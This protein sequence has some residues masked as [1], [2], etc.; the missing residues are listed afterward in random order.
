MATQSDERGSKHWDSIAQRW[1]LYS[2][3][4]RPG[5]EDVETFL[6]VIRSHAPEPGDAPRQGLILGVTPE[7]ATM[8]WPGRTMVTGADR[9]QEM[10]EQVWPGDRPGL[11]QALCVDWF[12]LPKPAR[13]YDLVL[14][15]GSF[16]TLGYPAELRRLLAA[17]A[18]LAAERA[19]LITRTFTRPTKRE[20]LASLEEAARAGEAGGFN[21]FRFR[22]AMALQSTPEAGVSLDEIWRLWQRLDCEIEDLS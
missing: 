15:D 14:A 10:I 7:I 1:H 3:P 2:S 20:S 22:L 21:A 5:A 11:R 4:L 6:R 12:E 19:L 16:N 18:G 13:A 17:L 8:A 9:S